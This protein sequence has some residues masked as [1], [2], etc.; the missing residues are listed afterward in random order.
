MLRDFRVRPKSRELGADV[1]HL[2]RES[3]MSRCG[4][5][6][7]AESGPLNW[8]ENVVDGQQQQRHGLGSFGTDCL[9]YLS[10]QRELAQRSSCAGERFTMCRRTGHSQLEVRN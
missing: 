3:G 2:T 6:E 1:A 4:L 5:S 9:G 7:L 8:G 10:M